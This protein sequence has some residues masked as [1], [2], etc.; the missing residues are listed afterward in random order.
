MLERWAALSED[1]A[2]I[3]AGPGRA[4]VSLSYEVAG[5]P[6]I[7][8]GAKSN[9]HFDP[10]D[11]SGELVRFFH[12]NRPSDEVAEMR[13]VPPEKTILTVAGPS[14]VVV[15]RH[16]PSSAMRMVGSPVPRRCGPRVRSRSSGQSGV[17]VDS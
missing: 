11:R 3:D 7:G 6:L 12:V 1:G 4:T 9:L 8:P 5:V 14:G 13:T 10:S 2:E 17:Q 16:T 15:V